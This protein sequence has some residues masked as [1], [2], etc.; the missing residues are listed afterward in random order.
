MATCRGK[1]KAGNRCKR[2]PRTGS[3]YCSWHGAETQ[4]PP[5]EARGRSDAAGSTT[6]SREE[7]DD[8]DRLWGLIGL[9]LIVGVLFSLKGGLRLWPRIF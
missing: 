8:I 6:G 5:N 7:Y 1:T 3:D 2:P 4:A 9:G